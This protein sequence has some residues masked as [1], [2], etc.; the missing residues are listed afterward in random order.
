MNSQD[1]HQGDSRFRLDANPAFKHLHTFI[2]SFCPDASLD[3]LNECSFS[4]GGLDLPAKI[5][6]LKLI[7]EK[8]IAIV[9]REAA[10]SDFPEH[11]LGTQ[12]NL[13]RELENMISDSD[14]VRHHFAIAIPVADRPAMLGKCLESLLDQ[15]RLYPYGGKSL[16]P[17]G[18]PLYKKISLFIFDDSR[19][20]QNIQKT[21]ELACWMRSSGIR[22]H[23]VGVEEQSLT[24]KGIP[25]EDR[26]KLAGLLGNQESGDLSH[27]GA[28]VTRNIALL[29]LR[30]VLKKSDEKFLFYFID[31]DEEFRVKISRGGR[32]EDIHFIHYFY[33]LDSLFSAGAIDVLTGK[34]VGDPPVSPSIMINTF[35]ND[36]IAFFAA[37]SDLEPSAPCV[38]HDKRAPQ[39]FSAEY[40]D[41]KSLFGYT[42][43]LSPTTYSCELTGTHTIAD[44][45]ADFS[46][47]ARGF[48]YGLHPTRT[49]YYLHKGTFLQTEPARTVYTGNY[50]FNEKGLHHFIPFA[51]LKLRMGGPTLGRLLRNRLRHRFVS[52]NL[53]LLHMRT[54][55]TG[56]DNE[57]R[58]G[59]SALE[60]GVDLS[61]EYQKQFW[62]D[63]MLF[64]VEDL[65]MK[66]Y[67]GKRFCRKEISVTVYEVRER[68]MSLY[69]EKRKETSLRISKL[70]D[71][72]CDPGRW[73][74]RIQKTQDAVDNFRFFY[75]SA[76]NNFG[77]SSLSSKR[78]SEE[79]G[80]SVYPEQIIKAIDSFYEDELHWNDLVEKETK[81]PGNS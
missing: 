46:K 78:F 63:V 32:S 35:L 77:K 21:K 62:G 73:W 76:E 66:G 45:F 56:S 54:L 29:Y 25:A 58:P 65:A 34:V 16:E 12:R 24:L 8:A 7:Y 64:S 48:F 60:K 2:S 30:A 6:E 13:Y 3:P 4:A 61:G 36:L 22:T 70:G 71:F 37:V 10:A 49:Q 43:P 69:L 53:P 1:I 55:D 79:A 72:L 44:C 20:P 40:H 51:N 75:E 33:W 18:L 23:Y 57:F 38:F 67:P 52:A 27:K 19:D 47:K 68:I 39:P 74:N 26:R 41:M 31:S 42:G 9:E 80:K 15:C 59:V 81:Y 28:S 17:D 14:D 5:D 11:L 50:V